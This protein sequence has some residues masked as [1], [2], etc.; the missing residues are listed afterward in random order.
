MS[1]WL[2]PN[3]IELE[4]VCSCV[5]AGG[6]D[7]LRLIDAAVAVLAAVFDAIVLVVEEAV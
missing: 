1:A 3:S 2:I 6:D 7:E 4:L 5:H